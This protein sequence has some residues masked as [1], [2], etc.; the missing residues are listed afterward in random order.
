[1]QYEGLTDGM[2]ESGG[3][4]YIMN[5]RITAFTGWMNN[6]ECGGHAD[7]TALRRESTDGDVHMNVELN[8]DDTGYG[9]K[10][11]HQF[12]NRWES[13]D[14]QRKMLLSARVSFK[15]VSKKICAQRR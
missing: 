1:M 11:M 3:F 14:G 2:Y 15:Q 8:D 9:Y 12:W 6:Y 4:S 5:H 13:W 10:R 7:G